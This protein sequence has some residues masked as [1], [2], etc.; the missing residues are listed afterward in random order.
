MKATLHF[1]DLIRPTAIGRSGIGAIHDTHHRH[2]HAPSDPDEEPHTH[3]HQ[4]GAL[5]NKHPHYP[6]LHHRHEHA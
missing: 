6:D 3:P 5:V 1:S 2:T 4:H